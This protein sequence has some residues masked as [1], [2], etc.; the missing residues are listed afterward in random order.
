MLRHY[1]ARC[2]LSD[3]QTQEGIASIEN[4]IWTLNML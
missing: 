1:R 3:D 2:R 4:E